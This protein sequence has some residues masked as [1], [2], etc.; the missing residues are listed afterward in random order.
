MINIA[1]GAFNLLPGFPM[2]GGRLLRSSIWA[3]SGNFALA[4]RIA[5][6]LGRTMA[7]ALMALGVVVLWEPAGWLLGSDQIQGLW[8]ILIGLFLNR[9]AGQTQRQARLLNYLRGYRADQ[10]M[11]PNVPVVPPDAVLRS[12]VYELPQ[13]Q[14]EV[15]CFVE[16]DG[17]VI[18][19]V[20]RDRLR[21]IPPERW[22]QVTAADLMI[23]ADKIIPAEPGDNGATL[24][25]RLD[26]EGLPG[27]PVVNSGVIAGLVTR[28]SLFRLLRSNRRLSL[29]RL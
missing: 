10:I 27:L 17:H 5:A 16:R 26:A 18:G 19:M 6:F 20:P 1:L 24:L 14:D 12:F 22:G 9:A 8:L 3:V 7:F 28:S 11:E 13:F 21:G 2:D 29:L 25:Q 15:C 23:A 4:T